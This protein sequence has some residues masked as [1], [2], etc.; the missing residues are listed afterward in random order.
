MRKLEAIMPMKAQPLPELAVGD[1]LKERTGKKIFVILKTGSNNR[2]THIIDIEHETS[3]R[4][5]RALPFKRKTDELRHRLSPDY[6]EEDAL[7]KLD[8]SPINPASRR[9]TP[10]FILSRRLESYRDVV[11]HPCLSK[12]WLLIKGLLGFD[13]ERDGKGDLP[14]PNIHGNEFE[15][16]LHKETRRKR[17]LRYSATAGI[18]EDT[19][20]RIF[21]R[22]CQ[23]GM[24]ADAVVDDY[25]L[26]GGRGEQRE[27]KYR[28][29]KDP[30]R[31]K[32]GAS[33][34]GK[35]VK[36]LLALASDYYFSFE[37][38]K[39]KRSQKTLE[40]ALAW[41]RATFLINRVVY[42]DRGEMVE[43]KLDSSVVLTKRQLQYFIH[44]NY[45][46][47]ERRIH[48]VGRRR[49]LLHERPLT[50]TLR[51]SRGPGERF[52][53]DATV[54]DIYLVGQILRTKVIGRPVLY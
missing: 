14:E 28:P 41:L 36:R 40:Q 46:Y 27:W 16:L 44:E 15:E 51:T 1:V 52:H 5:H 3:P 38:A 8:K 39:G 23:R 33:A 31:R 30:C 53:I 18:S 10:L 4:L 50:G 25:D 26:S 35:D 48:K 19:V 6:V 47:A 49:Y 21:R 7:E 24:N 22:Y 17:I 12:G 2:W 11:K 9:T 34:R 42:N 20:Y 29:G 32:L 45:T 37:Y 43:L 13:K 54:L